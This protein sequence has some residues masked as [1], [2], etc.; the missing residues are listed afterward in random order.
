MSGLFSFLGTGIVL[1]V[2]GLGLALAIMFGIGA[3]LK[4]DQPPPFLHHLFA[5]GAV[6]LLLSSI[7]AAAYTVYFLRNSNIATA[8]VTDIKERHDDDGNISH[9]MTYEFPD[10]SGKIY[11]GQTSIASN[12]GYGLGDTLAVR[13]LKSY[14]PT[15]RI[16]NAVN[17]WDLTGIAAFI[18]FVLG[19]C[20]WIY[21]WWHRKELPA[22]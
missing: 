12:A 21:R 1:I 20:S 8:T 14:P 18:A 16:D 3:T 13:Y 2:V 11:H 7:A 6:L 9:L 10:E 15:S 5:A 4:K 17:H 19:L 22:A